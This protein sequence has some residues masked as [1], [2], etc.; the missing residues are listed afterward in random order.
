M[1]NEFPNVVSLLTPVMPTQ[2]LSKPLTVFT[3]SYLF[4]GSSSMNLVS[5]RR[6]MIVVTTPPLAD[7]AVFAMV[8]ITLLPGTVTST[9]Y[10][11]PALNMN[12]VSTRVKAPIK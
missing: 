4:S 3:T 2:A 1:M 10:E 9:V 7:M 8:D 12:Q 11:L 5:N 6:R